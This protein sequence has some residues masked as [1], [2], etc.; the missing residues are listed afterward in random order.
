MA[1]QSGPIAPYMA[2][3]LSTVVRGISVRKESPATSM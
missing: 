3:G 1:K 2:V